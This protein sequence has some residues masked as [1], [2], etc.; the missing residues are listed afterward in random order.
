MLLTL[1]CSYDDL[2]ANHVAH[3]LPPAF[4]PRHTLSC[5]RR[6]FIKLIVAL[7]LG[8]PLPFGHFSL[9][10]WTTHLNFSSA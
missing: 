5:F 6:G 3:K 7:L 4:Q 1:F 8:Q 9:E 10:P 2:P